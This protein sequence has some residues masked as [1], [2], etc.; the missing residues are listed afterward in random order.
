[1]V[2]GGAGDGG[3]PTHTRTVVGDGR[4]LVLTGEFT[5]VEG[6][7]RRGLVKFDLHRNYVGSLSPTTVAAKAEDQV[8]AI[9]GANFAGTPS[10]AMGEGV[11][12]RKVTVASPARLDVAISSAG[13]RDGVRPVVVTNPD[14]EVARCLS[15]WGVGNV[16][17]DRP[18][19][20]VP[21]GPP[22]P[23]RQPVD[24]GPGGYWLV[25]SDGGIFPFGD[26]TF[27]GSTGAIKLAQPIVGMSATSTGRGY[28]L[29][30]ADGG[31]FAFGD[32][33]FHGSTGGMTLAQRML[34]MTSSAAGSGYWLVA[35]DGGIFNFGDARFKGST[36]D[37][38]LA[39]PIVG[40]TRSE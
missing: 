16:V 2:V 30:A 28:W 10:V 4:H 25:A 14:G 35:A 13:A 12:V 37:T 36:G 9:H 27:H 11:A 19:S 21:T 15:C 38:R 39:R 18:G 20:P 32:A 22:E 33:A 17:P 34:G 24:P 3:G 7:K 6:E 8:V 23:P 31:I 1:M 26:A 40:M 5:E 29:V